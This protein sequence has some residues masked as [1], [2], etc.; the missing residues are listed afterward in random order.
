MVRQLGFSQVHAL[1][2]DEAVEVGAFQVVPREAMDADVD[3]IFQ[4]KA[5]GL[6]VLN[7]VDSWIDDAI[8]A[9][10]AAE[11]PWDMVLWPFQ[12]MRELEV[13]APTRAVAAP[14]ALPEE[15]LAQLKTLDPRYVVPSSC[16]FL[17]EPWSWYNRA[18]FPISYAR[19]AQELKAALPSCEVVRLDPSVSVLLDAG[20]LRPAPPLAWVIPVGDQDVDYVYEGNAAPP[21]TADIARHFAPLTAPQLARVMEYCR[22]GLPDRYGATEASSDY[23]DRPRIWQLSVWD[24]AGQ[25]TRFRYRLEPGGGASPDD[26]G[27][28]PAWTTDIPA[29]KL[30]AALELGESLTSMYMRI[31][32]AV[33]DA[34]TERALAQAEVVDDP[35]IR[36]LFGDTFGAYQAAQLRR[37]LAP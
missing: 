17:Q 28:P 32:D 9:R 35:L 12:T 3:S 20:S 13:L 31:N 1:R 14:P 10:L 18:F 24:H 5:A 30:Y 25:A 2:L 16:Q 29:A 27:A 22:T 36:C 34:D 21:P 26:S 37:L 4:V 23:F 15:W 6:N 11:G 7:V 33:F 8:L 19:F